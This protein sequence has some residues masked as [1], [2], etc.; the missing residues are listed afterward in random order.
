MI[1]RFPFSIDSKRRIRFDAE[2]LPHYEYPDPEEDIMLLKEDTILLFVH[3]Y[4]LLDSIS[5]RIG[6]ENELEIHLGIWPDIAELAMRIMCSELDLSVDV[7]ILEDSNGGLNMIIRT[8]QAVE[9]D[10]LIE[11]ARTAFMRAW[12]KLHAY[13]SVPT[14][15]SIG[16]PMN[17][18]NMY[19]RADNGV[20]LGPI[21]TTLDELNACMAELVEMWNPLKIG[22]LDDIM[23][24]LLDP[25]RVPDYG[26]TSLSPHLEIA[27]IKDTDAKAQ[28][29]LR[30]VDDAGTELA[31]AIQLG[32]LDDMKIGSI[33]PIQHPG[34]R[35][36]TISQT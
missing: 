27:V 36:M 4:A 9:A 23:V 12:L 33:D 10:L 30:A 13:G 34:L 18:S 11:I 15:E 5:M 21:T 24:S 8:S 17:P 26:R 3:I 35:D 2:N 29:V 16:L 7:K 28:L 14:E 25:H 31:E 19:L 1:V 20:S 6:A 22:D 32:Y